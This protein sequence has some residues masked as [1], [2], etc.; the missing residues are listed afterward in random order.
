MGTCD[1]R[2]HRPPEECWRDALGALVWLF[3][4]C[5]LAA[6]EIF[7]ARGPHGGLLQTSAGESRVEGPSLSLLRGQGNEVKASP[8][9]AMAPA[10]RA[11]EPVLFTGGQGLRVLLW[12]EGATAGGAPV[13]W[14][15]Y[16]D[17]EYRGYQNP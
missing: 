17:N 10:A 12:L 5:P 8:T 9:P 4:V 2:A 16:T 3:A 14:S 13:A 6:A 15:R 7:T 11:Q 1:T